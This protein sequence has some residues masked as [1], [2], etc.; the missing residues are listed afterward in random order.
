[1]ILSI[2]IPDLCENLSIL[3]CICGEK[4]NYVICVHIFCSS[5]TSTHEYDE[6]IS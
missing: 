1:M 4:K 2:A 5:N 3:K 6:H